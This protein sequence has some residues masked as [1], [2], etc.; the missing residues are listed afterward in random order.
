MFFQLEDDPADWIIKSTGAKDADW[1]N[2][3]E[4]FIINGIPDGFYYA[5]HLH[6]QDEP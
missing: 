1:V 3:N 5:N 2:E 4:V 6:L